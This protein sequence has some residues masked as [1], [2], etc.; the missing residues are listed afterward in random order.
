MAAC[1][2]TGE[3][4]GVEWEERAGRTG[5]LTFKGIVGQELKAKGFEVEMEVLQG[6]DRP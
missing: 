1:L 5:N 4:A 2:L 3:L 6:R